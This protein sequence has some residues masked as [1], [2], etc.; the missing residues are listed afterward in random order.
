MT[1]SLAIT[2]YNRFESFLKENI[3]KYLEN[4]I[5]NEIVVCD[6]CSDDYDKLVKTYGDKIKVYKNDINLDCYKNKLRVSQYA[7]CDWICL[8]DSDNFCGKD[9]FD[10]LFKYWDMH[11]A[12]PSCIY[13]PEKA[14]P[15]F[16][17]SKYSGKIIDKTNWNECVSVDEPCFNTC[18]LVFHKSA[19][20][21]QLD[22]DI[23][24]HGVDSLYMNYTWVKFGMK[25][26]VVPG[27]MYTH[28][29]HAGSH[30][31]LNESKTHV[32]KNNFLFKI[33]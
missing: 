30:Y 22:H 33:T 9:Y 10:A 28:T 14:L 7:S 6:D 4:E 26:V 23:D 31:I 32:F 27:M 17:Y 24:P 2:T 18:N 1:L 16:D 8:M 13:M 19:L 3:D 20:T 11:G 15:N 12:D 29:V 25:L 21:C 5:I